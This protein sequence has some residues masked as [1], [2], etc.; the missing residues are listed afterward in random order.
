MLW[1][2]ILNTIEPVGANRPRKKPRTAKT[3]LQEQTHSTANEAG[4]ATKIPVVITKADE[5]TPKSNPLPQTATSA[6]PPP[7]MD[8]TATII[9]STPTFPIPVPDTSRFDNGYIHQGGFSLQ[10]Y[11]DA[12]AQH[13]ASIRAADQNVDEI[14]KTEK[15]AMVKF[16]FGM[17][18]NRERKRLAE[19]MEKAGWAVIDRGGKGA[20]VK[21]L[22]GW[23]VVEEV[24]RG[25]EKRKVGDAGRGSK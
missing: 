23:A 12:C 14:G 1:G 4:P 11:T 13:V 15:D 3:T 8:S 2:T 7:E 18:E 19:D 6:T 25:W 24:L 16:V 9:A 5:G 10:E 22:C 20:G 17:R 21:F